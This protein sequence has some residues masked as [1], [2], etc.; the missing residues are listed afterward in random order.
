MGL[1]PQRS[2]AGVIDI[3]CHCGPD[4][5]PRTLDTIDL[6]RLAKAREMRGI[7]V[8]NH[9]EPTASS[10]MLARKIVPGIAIFG[11]VTLNLSVGGMNPRAVEQMA[12]VAGGAGRFVWMGSVDTEAQVRH[13]GKIRPFVPIARKGELLPEVIE[14]IE[15]VAQYDLVLETG[16]SSRDEVVMLVHEACR[17]GVNRIVVTHAMIAPIHMKTADLQQAAD[18]G[19]WIEFVYN[20]LIGPHKEFEIGDYAAAIRAVGP[21]RCVLASDLGQTVNPVHPDGLV[22]FFDG[23]QSEGF[24]AAEIDTMSKTNPARILSIDECRSERNI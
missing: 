2:L 13:D 8:K 15:V 18:A 4:S 21:D 6:A 7:V 16:H 24:T 17:R 20:G 12:K 22:A 10:A 5:I 1:N 11:G 19:A 9:F 3:H 23:L 14:V